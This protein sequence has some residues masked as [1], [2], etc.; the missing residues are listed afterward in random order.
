MNDSQV[1]L[2][3]AAEGDLAAATEDLAVA[4]EDLAAAMAEDL[5]ER[6]LDSAGKSSEVGSSRGYSKEVVENL[7]RVA[8]VSKYYK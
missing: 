4:T 6:G 3:A 5:V 8:A 2:A 1:D 7:G